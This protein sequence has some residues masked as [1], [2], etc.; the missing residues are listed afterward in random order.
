MKTQVAIVGA[1]PAGLL[2]GALLHQY[3]VR[4]IVVEQRSAAYALGRILAGV[5]EQITVDLLAEAG[6]DQPLRAEGLP[7]EQYSMRALARVWKAESFSWRFTGLLRRFPENGEFGA[8]M[9]RAELDDLFG[10]RAAQHVM[11]ENYVGLAL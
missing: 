6:V 8:K 2:R 10:S 1:G 5:A 7:H 11:A 9:Q 3:G 4:N